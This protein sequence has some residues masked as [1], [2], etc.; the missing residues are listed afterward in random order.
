[1]KIISH[2][3]NL[4]GKNLSRENNT[5]FIDECI[6][7]NFDVEIDLWVTDKIYL[8]HDYPEY[9]IDKKFLLDRSD[10]LWIHAKNLNAVEFLY[11]IKELNWFWHETD[12][13]TLTSK[14]IPWCYPNNFISNGITVLTDQN[15]PNKNLYGI[16]TDYPVKMKEN[17][18]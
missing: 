1:M 5:I 16:C 4:N 7:L 10:N 15:L 9:P 11:N 8:G 14:G 13:L 17:L 12:K 18:L 3:G 6:L 2:R